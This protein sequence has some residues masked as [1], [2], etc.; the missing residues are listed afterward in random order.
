MPPRDHW[1][2]AL[3]AMGVFYGGQSAMLPHQRSRRL[4]MVMLLT[5][6]GPIPGVLPLTAAAADPVDTGTVTA[7]ITVDEGITI[8]FADGAIT[9]TGSPGETVED[10]GAVSMTVTTN[11]ATGYNVAVDPDTDTFP[12]ATSGGAIVVTDL[13]V[14]DTSA[15]SVAGAY[16]NLLTTALVINNKTTVSA[17][18]GDVINNDYRLTITGDTAA[19]VYTGTITYIATINP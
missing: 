13:Q 9:L 6:M 4:V 12:G 7:T 3:S 14:R 16:V 15:T 11:N 10:L 19:D 5:V 17:P 1:P 18:A 8:A 2:R